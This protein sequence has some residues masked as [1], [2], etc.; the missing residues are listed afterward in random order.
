MSQVLEVITQDKL[1][2]IKVLGYSFNSELGMSIFAPNIE[3]YF[4]D[5]YQSEEYY[6]VL[7]SP[8]AQSELTQYITDNILEIHEKMKSLEL[9]ETTSTFL[10]NGHEQITVRLSP[11][12]NVRNSKAVKEFFSLLLSK[13]ESDTALQIKQ[14]IAPLSDEEF[15]SNYEEVIS[16][17]EKPLFEG[18]FTFEN[19]R[20][21]NL[22]MSFSPYQLGFSLDIIHKINISY[23][24]TPKITL[25]EAESVIIEDDLYAP[26]GNKDIKI[27]TLEN[28]Q[29]DDYEMLAQKH[30]IEIT[31]S[32]Q[33]KSCAMR[34]LRKLQRQLSR[35]YFQSLRKDLESF[36]K[37]GFGLPLA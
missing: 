17:L 19:D 28:I 9:L 31:Q 11:Q 20:P 22:V 5:L 8:S 21:T 7:Q 26:I 16:E 24:S 32:C 4:S 6:R 35:K 34:E 23:R 13:V 27:L 10:E 18:I 1:N 3:N 12:I 14:Y 25:P 30:F 15:A 36:Y 37:K 33:T 2:F 29:N